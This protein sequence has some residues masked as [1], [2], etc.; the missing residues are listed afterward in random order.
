MAFDP[1]ALA[2]S[3]A[4]ATAGGVVLG[5]GIF[6][7][8]MGTV[9]N[10]IQPVFNFIGGGGTVRLWENT[11]WGCGAF[12]AACIIGVVSVVLGGLM[13]KMAGKS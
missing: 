12:L 13:I 9:Q 5:L 1:K 7:F 3:P 11:Y 10:I 2:K 4:F 6:W 8:I